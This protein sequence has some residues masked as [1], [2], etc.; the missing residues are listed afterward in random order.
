M[1]PQPIGQKVSGQSVWCLIKELTIFRIAVGFC[2]SLGTPKGLSL[3]RG[4]NE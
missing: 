2:P 4:G 1:R 3:A